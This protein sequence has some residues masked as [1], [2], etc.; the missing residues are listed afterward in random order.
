MIYWLII[1]LTF[2]S[3]ALY[4]SLFLFKTDP[5]IISITLIMS[6]VLSV[7]F[8]LRMYKKELPLLVRHLFSIKQLPQ[9]SLIL[10]YLLILAAILSPMVLTKTIDNFT[11]VQFNG[12][13]DYY[14]HLYTIVAIIQKGIPPNHPYFPPDS[15]SYYF[16]YYTI[17][18]GLSIALSLPPTVSLFFF[19]LITYGI[20]LTALTYIYNLHLKGIFFRLSAL[21]LFFVG[22][23]VD[24]IP[25]SALLSGNINNLIRNQVFLGDRGLRV[26][27]TFMTM[28]QSPQHFLAAVLTVVLFHHLFREKNNLLVMVLLT[29]F[30]L[31]SSSF[32]AMTLLIWFAVT[33]L[34]VPKTRKILIKTT[35]SSALIFL[36]TLSIISGKQNFFYLNKFMPYPFINSPIEVINFLVNT[37]VTVFMQYGPILFILPV[38]FF[39]KKYYKSKEN[40]IIFLGLLVPFFLTWIIKS[41]NFNDFS[42]RLNT[43]AYLLVPVII[44]YFLGGIKNK[45]VKTGLIF[46]ILA[47]LLVG[48]FAFFVEYKYA[49]VSRKI[50]HPEVSQLILEI[51]KLPKNIQLS[52]LE[53]D[54]WV[55]LIPPLGFRDIL[56]PHLW[57]SA[58]STSGK[59]GNEHSIYEQMAFNLFLNPTSG[60]S[61]DDLINKRNLYFSQY[62]DYFNIYGFDSLLV[63]NGVWVKNG[64]N[65]LKVQLEELMVTPMAITPNFTLFKRPEIISKLKSN[66]ISV[67]ES[68]GNLIL[69]KESKIVLE[70]G[71]YFLTSCQIGSKFLEFE[72]Y[73]EIFNVYQFEC[74]G[75]LFYQPD[76]REIKVSGRTNITQLKAYRIKISPKLEK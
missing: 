4:L 52:A 66:K 57:D 30:I 14:K 29:T 54:D 72:D 11:F 48:C 21:L 63:K 62:A 76:E 22:V 6:L 47:T 51:R 38:I 71:L 75:N 42:M 49:W 13:E 61:E 34:L 65:P 50:F 31:L 28:I 10:L 18:A 67:D 73:Y 2:T 9:T 5:L 19:V 39:V 55:Y 44:L 25:I 16:G 27:N 17:P 32:V 23:G 74:A 53:K 40:S 68:S 64:Q 58:V 37:P 26:V 60:T 1:P 33:F 46:I 3:I 45:L 56:V 8:S 12:L 20:A 70:K 7:F 15:M 36:P 43:P 35:L 59:I 24:V 41:Y 69:I